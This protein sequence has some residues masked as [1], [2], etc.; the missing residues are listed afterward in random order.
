MILAG[1]ALLMTAVAAIGKVWDAAGAAIGLALLFAWRSASCGCQV[2]RVNH[3][4]PF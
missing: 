4:Q 1:G 2:A 3:N